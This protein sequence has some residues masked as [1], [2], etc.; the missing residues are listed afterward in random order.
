[1]I[2]E[3][4]ELQ[5][6]LIHGARTYLALDLPLGCLQKSARLESIISA[7]VELHRAMRSDGRQERVVFF[8]AGTPFDPETMQTH[9]KGEGPITG[10]LSFGFHGHDGMLQKA[11]VLI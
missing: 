7:A 11:S 6:R 3:I 5:V 2:A 4:P 8:T 1:M 10:C 9:G